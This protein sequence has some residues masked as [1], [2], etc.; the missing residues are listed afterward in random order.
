MYKLMIVEDEALVREAI[1]KMIDFQKQGFEVVAV[2]E[3]GQDA[4]EKYA[5]LSPDLVITDICMPFISG[6]E[7]AAMIA[8]AGRGT[9]VVIITGF[10]DFNFAK[11]AIKSQVA[12]Y[13]LKPVTPGE[14][15]EV[16]AEA[17]KRLDEQRDQRRQIQEAQRQIHLSS[18]LVRDQMFNRLIQGSVSLASISDDLRLFGLDS[19]QAYFQIALI[20]ADRLE[21]D[22]RDL[23]VNIQLLQFMIAN[24]VTELAASFP[25]FVAFQLADGRTALIGSADASQAL[26]LQ[27]QELGNGVIATIRQ[28]L[29]IGVTVGC[30]LA[31]TDITL[32]NESFASAQR[33]LDY[34]FLLPDKALV[35]PEDI[36]KQAQSID[37]TS[38]EDEIVR[39][40]RLQDEHK[41]NAAI[42]QLV[43]AVRL[44]FQ[45]KTDTQFEWARL[46]SRL[47]GAVSSEA[48]ADVTLPD[49]TMPQPD[50]QN[51]LRAMSDWL[52]LYCLTCIGILKGRRN[53]ENRR[54]SLVATGYIRE[55]FAD[56]QLSLLE[57]CNHAAVSLSHFSQLFKEETGKTF[58][59]YLTEIRMER[60][61]E[62]LRN[63]DRML[64]D[65]AEMVGYEN[66]AYFTV[67]FKKHVGIGPR[68][69]RKQYRQGS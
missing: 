49:Q 68:E 10:D 31:T 9:Q 45:S 60:A 65:I 6:L 38:L 48:G 29:K 19:S 28:V 50:D 57:V 27:L 52:S 23:R 44:S 46:T 61:R 67:A 11:Q 22:A 20:K 42:A 55:H 43:Q 56:S 25:G 17:R 1:L 24:I 53:Q 21:T 16:L 3:D 58:I 63:S 40:V 62:L 8:E 33:S 13:I 54:L 26:N 47:A 36:R 15:I 18:P 4:T 59:E 14:F 37:L 41:L 7:L 51:F 66:P 39:Q 35:L 32:L 69:Y 12:S 2:C 64:Y 30:G 34:R 5:R